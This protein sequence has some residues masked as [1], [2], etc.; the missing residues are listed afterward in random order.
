MAFGF[1]YSF[2]RQER[3]VLPPRHEQGVELRIVH[4]RACSERTDA[5]TATTKTKEGIAQ[6]TALRD[7]RHVQ[8]VR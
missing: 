1:I 5:Q 4:E 6:H 3:P 2:E 7:A 8:P